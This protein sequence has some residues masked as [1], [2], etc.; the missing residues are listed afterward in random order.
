MPR[1]IVKIVTK[2]F[3]S[4]AVSRNVE[5]AYLTANNLSQK[6]PTFVEFRTDLV[7]RA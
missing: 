1:K 6:I 3:N 4:K 5:K 7:T 2:F